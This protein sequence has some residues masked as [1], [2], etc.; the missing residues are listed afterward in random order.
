[1]Q[2]GAGARPEWAGKRL[3]AVKLMKKRW[4]GGW[5]ECQ[6]LKELEVCDMQFPSICVS[7]IYLS[8]VA[9]RNSFSSQCHSLVRFL[10]PSRHQGTLLCV[11]VHGGQ[12]VSS[13]QGP[14]RPAPRW[15]SCFLH[16]PSNSV[17]SR[18]HTRKR[19]LSSGYEA[20]ECVSN[21]HW[22]FRLHLRVTY[23][24]TTRSEGEGC[25]CHYQAGRFWTR[26]RDK[27]PPS[28][29]RI[30]FHSLVSCPRSLAPQSRLFKSC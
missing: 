11:R 26:P 5:D 27:E 29:H 1:M 4:E 25:R 9:A 19:L 23:R 14:Q 24:A 10:S 15:R 20:R 22:S 6:K 28:I 17:G 2:C 30:C 16:I 3:V 21:N 18:S 8:S 7:I 12:S 13:H